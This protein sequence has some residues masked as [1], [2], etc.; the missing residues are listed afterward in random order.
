MFIPGTR[1]PYFVNDDVQLYYVNLLFHR[2]SVWY[3]N[4]CIYA[5][6]VYM[7]TYIDILFDS[8]IPLIIVIVTVSIDQTSHYG[9]QPGDM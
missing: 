4:V 3:Q 2:Y 6:F 8:G 9:L 5:M 7:L 1:W